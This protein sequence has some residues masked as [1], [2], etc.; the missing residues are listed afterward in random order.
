MLKEFFG[1]GGYA[2]E[3]EGYFS[4]QHLTFVSILT[5]IMIT[6]AILFAGRNKN[7][8]LQEKNRVLMVAAIVMDGVELIKILLEC[9]LNNEWTG[10]LNDL[11]L[12]LCS[13]QFITLPL[14]AF[15]HGKIKE[16]SLDFVAIFGLLGAI[17]G[18]YCAGNNYACYPVLSFTNVFSGIT[19]TTAGFAALYIIFTRMASMNKRH[20]PISFA[21]I[22]VFSIAAYIANLLLGTNYMFLMRGDGTP[23][24]ILFNLLGGSPVLYPIGV[25]AL[26]IVYIVLV[27]HLCCLVRKKKEA[28]TLPTDGAAC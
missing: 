16:A 14:A 17:L 1:I 27:Y 10:W 12:F 4:W 15:C 6:L 11:P 8:S 21:I 22:F 20:I 23:Y 2:R 26:F 18:T 28:H 13:I 24:D 9:G 19:H 3:A 5:L 7:K 25:V